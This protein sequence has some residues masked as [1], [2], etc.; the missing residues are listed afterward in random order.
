M[1]ASQPRRFPQNGAALRR[2]ARV[3]RRILAVFGLLILLVVA[4]PL[5]SWWARLYAGP[6]DQPKGDVLIVLSAARDENGGISYSSYWR[7]RQAVYAW[8]TGGFSR[9][10]T[11]GGEGPGIQNYLLAN[12]VPPS[13]M[14]AEWRSQSTRESGINVARLLENLPGK[15]VLL[16]S[17]FHMYRA[18]RVFRNV[19]VDAAPMAVPDVLH[20]T[21]HWPGRFGACWAM[22][23]ES[24]K[25]VDYKLRG[26][27]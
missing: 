13:A 27:I 5:V 7:A 8:Q 4:T 9:I 1:L 18:I 19:G 21:E 20:S 12:G 3:T 10:V 6:I 14:I 26:W 23:V 22:A 25:I 17:D 16:T 24:A 15:R 2:M 11:S